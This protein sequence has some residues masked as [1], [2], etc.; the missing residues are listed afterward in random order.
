ML[1]FAN[2]EKHT[3]F[4][5]ESK[6]WICSIYYDKADETELLIDILSFGPVA[7][8]LEPEP[9]LCIAERVTV[10]RTMLFAGL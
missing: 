5:E 2:Y 1:Q 4:D 7:R 10:R 6:C 8:V 3:E 9:F